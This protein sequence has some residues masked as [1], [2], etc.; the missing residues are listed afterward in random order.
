MAI[1]DEV[2]L[3]REINALIPQITALVNLL[4]ELYNYAK[5]KLDDVGHGSTY[6]FEELKPDLYRRLKLRIEV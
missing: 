3:R 6:T 4:Q 1:E 5:P 2:K